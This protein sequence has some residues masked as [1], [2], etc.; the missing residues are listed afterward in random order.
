MNPPVQQRKEKAQLR[1]PQMM[2]PMNKIHRLSNGILIWWLFLPPSM[3]HGTSSTDYAQLN[4]TA[5]LSSRSSPDLLLVY[6]NVITF[7]YISLNALVSFNKNSI[8]F[9]MQKPWPSYFQQKCP[10]LF[11]GHRTWPIY[12]DKKCH[13]FCPT[14]TMTKLQ[15]TEFYLHSYWT[16]KSGK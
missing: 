14:L 11:V 9:I 16:N 8:S 10:P 13:F 1:L 12:S 5:L 15:P 6:T 2:L 4:A 3:Q 7:A